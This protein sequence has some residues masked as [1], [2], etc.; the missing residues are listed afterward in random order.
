MRSIGSTVATA[1]ITAA[2][3][4]WAAPD[5][6]WCAWIASELPSECHLRSDCMGLDCSVD[7]FYLD[8]IGFGAQ[9]NLCNDPVS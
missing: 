7:L 1:I 3:S 4:A 6:S 5:E 9:L 8:T 2:V